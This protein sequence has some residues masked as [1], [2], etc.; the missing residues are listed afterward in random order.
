MT[1]TV[2]VDQLESVRLRN[3]RS[4]VRQI[5]IQQSVPVTAV[6]CFLSNKI[7]TYNFDQPFTTVGHLRH[8]ISSGEGIPLEAF[9]LMHGGML[10]R[11]EMLLDDLQ[12]IFRPEHNDMIT[13]RCYMLPRPAYIK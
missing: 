4:Y 5:K 3:G 6:V 1:F 7:N 9:V 13:K 2:W 8:S 12:A 11:D 10:L